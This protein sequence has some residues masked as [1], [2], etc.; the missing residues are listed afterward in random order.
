MLRR[1]L[2]VCVLA[3]GVGAAGC[4]G[5]DDTHAPVAHRLLSRVQQIDLGVAAIAPVPAT[6]LPGPAQESPGG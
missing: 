2:L 4:G 1:A 5:G 6:R 3:L